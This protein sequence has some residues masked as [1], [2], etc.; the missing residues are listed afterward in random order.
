MTSAW[1][2][3]SRSTASA[4][5]GSCRAT[6][7][8]AE[9]AKTRSSSRA[10]WRTP[11]TSDRLRGAGAIV[12]GVNDVAGTATGA[13]ARIADAIAADP[14]MA[15]DRVTRPHPLLLMLT[16]DAMAIVVAPACVWDAGRELLKPFAARF[17]ESSALLVLLGRPRDPN[18][19]QALSRGLA[20]ILS[21]DP[22]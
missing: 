9:S 12:E 16:R 15:A 8:W 14:R 2:R 7:S 1:R 18:V 10:S 13:L 4:A 3:R 17:A 11:P 20:C 22:T 21:D 6:S 19:A 5:R